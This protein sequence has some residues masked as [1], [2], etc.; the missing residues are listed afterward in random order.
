M[1][2]PVKSFLAAGAAFAAGIAVTAAFVASRPEQP[3]V[4]QG[5]VNGSPSTGTQAPKVAGQVPTARVAEA[6]TWVDPVSA[7]GPGS[8]TKPPLPPLVFHV[9]RKAPDAAVTRQAGIAVPPPRRPTASELLAK[10]EPQVES[11]VAS[12]PADGPTTSRVPVLASAP[13]PQAPRQTAAAPRKATSAHAAASDGDQDDIRL[14]PGRPSSRRIYVA[15]RDDA[16]LPSGYYPPRH[17]EAFDRYEREF[18]ERAPVYRRRVTAAESGGILRWLD[19][20]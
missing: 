7:R 17:I 14:A 10:S 20:P 5:M 19:Q 2:A 3:S 4:Q 6:D 8:A 16:A 13:K 15:R 12:G 1:S 9:E 18:E 11:S